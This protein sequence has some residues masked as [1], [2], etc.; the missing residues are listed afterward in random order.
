VPL[1]GDYDLLGLFQEEPP[2]DMVRIGN[3]GSVKMISYHRQ[4]FLN[5]WGHVPRH[6]PNVYAYDSTLA[7]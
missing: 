1:G 6:L 4:A 3:D 2:Q 7:H 5:Y